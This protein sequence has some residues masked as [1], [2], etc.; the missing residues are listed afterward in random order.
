VDAR[1]TGA[2]TG[3]SVFVTRAGAVWLGRVVPHV[4]TGAAAPQ[5]AQNLPVPISASPHLVHVFV[6][7]GGMRGM[8]ARLQRFV[9]R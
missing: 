2:S 3:G 5:E 6:G 4:G 1:V 7:V 8:V 9:A